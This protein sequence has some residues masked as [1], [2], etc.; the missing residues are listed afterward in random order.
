MPDGETGLCEIIGEGDGWYQARRL[1]E[2]NFFVD[3]EGVRIITKLYP[4]AA[5]EKGPGEWTAEEA[6]EGLWLLTVEKGNE[7][8]LTTALQEIIDE[9][10]AAAED[11]TETYTVYI[12]PGMEVSLTGDAALTPAAEGALPVILPEHPAD[13]FTETVIFSGSGRFFCDLQ[14]SEYTN[15]YGYRVRPLP[16]AENSFATVDSLF[17]DAYGHAESV[18]VI[19]SDPETGDTGED[20]CSTRRTWRW[21]RGTGDTGEDEWLIDLFPGQFLKLENCI[22]EICYGNG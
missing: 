1:Y 17:A 5:Q 7:A 14:L 2:P 16:G 3:R 11:T 12:L 4:E 13:M 22:L 10:D 8:H 15:Y 18:T 9:I 20:E 6:D 19:F 21:W